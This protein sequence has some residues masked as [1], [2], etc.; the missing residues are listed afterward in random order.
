MTPGRN[1]QARAVA[2]RAA[3]G[4][5][6]PVGR[7]ASVAGEGD[8]MTG[9]G[10]P[11]LTAAALLRLVGGDLQ[12]G[13]G[14]A[15]RSLASAIARAVE[16]GELR[17]ATLLPSERSLAAELGMSRGTV[18]AAFD[19]LREDG[20]VL[21][22]RGSGTWVR[23]S[24]AND[25]LVDT[26]EH[27]A[28]AR[29]RRLTARVI[30][31][32]EGD[33]IDLGLSVL[34]GPWELDGI[35]LDVALSELVAAGGRHG[36]LPNGTEELRDAIAR[37]YSRQGMA[38]SAAQI[39]ITHGAQ[40]ALSLAARL[41]VHPGDT[42]AIESPTFPG[43]IDAFSRAG[44][45]FTTVPSDSGGAV[46]AE[47]DAALRSGRNRLAYVVPSCH[48]VTGAVMPE[49]RRREIAAAVDDGVSWLIEDETLAPLRFAGT[50]PP[51]IAAF[52][53]S[54]RHLVIGSLSKEVWAGLR[55]GWV[56]AD[57]AVVARLARW[58]AATDLGASIQSQVVALRCLEGLEERTDRLRSELAAR[59]EGLRALLARELPSWSVQPPD[60]GLS[61]WCTL[62]APLADA[63]AVV[64]PAHGVS[65][66]P[67]SATSADDVFGDR[68][69]L[70]FAQRPE[71]LAEAVRR[72]ASAWDAVATAEPGSGGG[73]ARDTMPTGKGAPR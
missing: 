30:D 34:D 55:I 73:S 71:V 43:A 45:R 39:S 28:A 20:V 35:D 24:P 70:S 18:V 58:R 16:R 40:H 67:G 68:V 54:D 72:L 3:C 62:P 12:G 8:D 14:P 32:P 42:V 51:P 17:G 56:R 23:S 10:P 5:V 63:L 36:Y 64:A 2:G 60:G 59:A 29:A 4:H 57:P 15:F 21:R 33:I 13:R 50:A 9:S 11:R 61:L 7:G 47:L 46:V 41:L 65:I 27:Q 6:A 37:R 19:V 38:T 22:R 52:G 66:L 44:A 48:S 53:R 25:G 1:R 26:Y 49:H 69:R 31:V